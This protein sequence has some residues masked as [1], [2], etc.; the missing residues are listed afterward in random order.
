MPRGW[1]WI[2]P[3]NFSAPGG[4]RTPDPWL[5]RPLLYPAELQA[6]DAHPRTT[7]RSVDTSSALSLAR[8]ATPWARRTDSNGREE[9]GGDALG[10]VRIEPARRLCPTY[11]AM[12]ATAHRARVELA[13]TTKGE[14]Y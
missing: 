12:A 4:I 3:Q 5:R 11:T 10:Q 8:R 2:D 6:R 1:N 14:R 13:K 7:Q 9:D